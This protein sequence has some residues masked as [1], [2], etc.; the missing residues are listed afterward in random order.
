MSTTPGPYPLE[1]KKFEKVSPNLRW[2]TYTVQILQI[3]GN[4]LFT[5]WDTIGAC[6][7][8]DSENRGLASGL[9]SS[10]MSS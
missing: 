5:A 8:D 1:E 6:E 9:D 2:I 10:L 3:P 4:F 7:Y